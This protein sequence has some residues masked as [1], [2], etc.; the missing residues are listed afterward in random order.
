MKVTSTAFC[1][2]ETSDAIS[3]LNSRWKGFSPPTFTSAL[4]SMMKKH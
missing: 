4:E 3:T 1:E 2:N